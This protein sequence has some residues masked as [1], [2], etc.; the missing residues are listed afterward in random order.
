MLQW[1]I[2]DN[3]FVILFHVEDRFVLVIVIK[4]YSRT[5]YWLLLFAKRISNWIPCL[6]LA[7]WFSAVSMAIAQS[8]KDYCRYPWEILKKD[9]IPSPQYLTPL[10]S[11][12]F[13]PMWR[14]F[15]GVLMWDSSNR[16]AQ[17]LHWWVGNSTLKTL[18]IHQWV[19]HEQIGL[20]PIFIPLY[21]WFIDRVW[22]QYT[23]TQFE[24][25]NIDPPPGY[26]FPIRITGGS[27]TWHVTNS[28]HENCPITWNADSFNMFQYNWASLCVLARSIPCRSRKMAWSSCIV[29]CC[30]WVHCHAVPRQ[31]FGH[32]Q[33]VAASTARCAIAAPSGLPA[34]PA[35]AAAAAATHSVD[36]CRCRCRI[37]ASIEFSWSQYPT[38]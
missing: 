8:T 12:G 7:P 28:Q 13:T 24:L 38:G 3:G 15:L 10:H 26:P 6:T 4:L 5:I 2:I 25:Y 22:L 14:H 30:P 18:A 27:M 23:T 11:R 20:V 17:V 16:N 35:A 31:V 21:S 33:V 34:P 36:S 29:R 37:T 32:A 9:L 19:N 1:W